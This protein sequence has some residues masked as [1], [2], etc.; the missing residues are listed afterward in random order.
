ME[1][2]L[3][4]RPAP[5]RHFAGKCFSIM[6]PIW[7]EVANRRGYRKKSARMWGRSHTPRMT[8]VG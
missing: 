3:V 7:I 8:A 1:P 4:G 2:D 6:L 5:G